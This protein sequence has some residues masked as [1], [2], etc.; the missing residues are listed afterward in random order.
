MAKRKPI[1]D[2][3]A[4]AVGDESVTCFVVYK[5]KNNGDVWCP[6]FGIDEYSVPR[7]VI[8]K[9]GVAKSKTAPNALQN[10]LDTLKDKAREALGL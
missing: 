9:H 4:A 7:S 8:E 5:E 2:S 6:A 1:P 10:M 3:F